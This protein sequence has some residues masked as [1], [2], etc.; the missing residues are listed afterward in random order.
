MEKG[1]VA[2][3]DYEFLLDAWSNYEDTNSYQNLDKENENFKRIDL[4]MKKIKQYYEQKFK[5]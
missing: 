5:K 4:E 2:L 1:V 3:V